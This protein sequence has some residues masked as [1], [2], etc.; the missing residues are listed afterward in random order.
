[1]A[2]CT[3]TKRSAGLLFLSGGKLLIVR[4]S[5]S[6][7]NAGLWGLPGGRRDPGESAAVTAWREAAEEM[8]RVPTAEVLSRCRVTRGTKRYD[9]FICQASDRAVRKFTPKLNA[10]HDRYKWATLQWCLAHRASLHP[11]L[12]E[13][14]FDPDVLVAMAQQLE[15]DQGFA[16]VADA[17]AKAAKRSAA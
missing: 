2:R 8:H 7:N 6:S 14:L 16:R 12:A 5:R 10:E 1:M 15:G 11:V 3:P 13:L 9:I 17:P 4:R